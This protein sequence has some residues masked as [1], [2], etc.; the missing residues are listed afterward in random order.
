MRQQRGRNA[1]SSYGWL[2]GGRPVIGQATYVTGIIRDLSLLPI[3]PTLRC[4]Q[5]QMQVLCSIWARLH[6]K[7][8]SSRQQQNSQRACLNFWGWESCWYVLCLITRLT[9]H[10]LGY[11]A[12]IANHIIE[13]G[14]E[15]R[16]RCNSC[17]WR[18]ESLEAEY[19]AQNMNDLSCLL[20]V[21][22]V[23]TVRLTLSQNLP[24]ALLESQWPNSCHLPLFWFL[25]AAV[26]RVYKHM[27]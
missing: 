22:P 15:F 25:R 21:W 9:C 11:C 2:L 19:K 3:F 13:L 18:G 23:L 10:F 7:W 16:H 4:R 8:P 17:C 24:I 5:S 1:T 14:G 20:G 26:L 6:T 12:V 27:L